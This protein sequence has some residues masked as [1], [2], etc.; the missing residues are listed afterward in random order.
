MEIKIKPNVDVRSIH[1]VIE[2]KEGACLRDALSI[3]VPQ[4]LDR[5]TEQYLG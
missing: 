5:K 4:V 1:S 3:I 2:V